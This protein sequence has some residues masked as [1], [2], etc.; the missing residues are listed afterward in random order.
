MLETRESEFEA[1]AVVETLA[2][3]VSNAIDGTDEL[4]I[5]HTYLV[6]LATLRPR[7]RLS[8]CL[9]MNRRR[10][11][12]QVRVSPRMALR[13]WGRRDSSTGR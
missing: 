8:I 4:F 13:V 2:N 10:A 1:R 12:C 7:G 9:Q 11:C 6:L 3:G 5:E